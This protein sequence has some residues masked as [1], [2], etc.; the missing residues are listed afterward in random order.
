M[1]QFPDTHRQHPRVHKR[2]QDFVFALWERISMQGKRQ[3]ANNKKQQLLQQT[4]QRGKKTLLNNIL[5][6]VSSLPGTMLSGATRCVETTNTHRQ[7]RPNGTSFAHTW[8]SWGE[9]MQ[10]AA[11]AATI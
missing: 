7:G 9:K 10:H 8:Q 1:F 4:Y 5:L 3:L 2:E 6:S 11:A